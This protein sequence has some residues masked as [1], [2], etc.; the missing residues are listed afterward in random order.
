MSEARLQETKTSEGQKDKLTS[1]II[2]FTEM[3]DI[4]ITMISFVT[5]PPFFTKRWPSDKANHSCESVLL[6]IVYLSS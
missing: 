5:W 1:I 2:P 3:Q 6:T 4:F